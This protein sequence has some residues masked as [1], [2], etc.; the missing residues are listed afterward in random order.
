MQEDNLVF[1]GSIV[2]AFIY[3]LAGAYTGIF[4][5]ALF[6]QL[7][8]LRLL[9]IG[10]GYAVGMAIVAAYVYVKDAFS[11]VFIRD[12]LEGPVGPGLCSGRKSVSVNEILLA[13]S[14]LPSPMKSGYLSLADESRLTLYCLYFSASRGAE[15]IEEISKRQQAADVPGFGDDLSHDDTGCME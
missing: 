5:L 4:L 2:R 1:R 10:V 14:R 8:P 7:P 15:I 11:I 3:L 13:A 9:M 6:M 12:T